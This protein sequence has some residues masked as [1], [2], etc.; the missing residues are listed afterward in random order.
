MNHHKDSIKL[1]GTEI[2]PREYSPQLFAQEYTKLDFYFFS[3]ISP[4]EFIYQL[5][6]KDREAIMP[7]MNAISFFN[8]M[9]LWFANCYEN[10]ISDAKLIYIEW[11]VL[12]AKEFEYLNNF[13]GLMAAILAWN[14]LEVTA[15][16]EELG[17]EI[18]RLEDLMSFHANY[19]NYRTSLEQTKTPCIPFLGLFIKDLYLI[20][21]YNSS[22]IDNLINISKL[23]LIS[24]RCRRLKIWQSVP[25][26]FHD[27]KEGLELY[28]LLE[29]MK[30]TK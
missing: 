2:L 30:N 12:V 25:Y 28:S 6:T 27:S 14:Q 7:L 18:K 5:H 21:E 23:N 4:K 11:L 17:L 20:E 24:E 1:P 22:M 8:K 9:T 16:S 19:K 29:S 13:N 26:K 10:E 3:R 15:T